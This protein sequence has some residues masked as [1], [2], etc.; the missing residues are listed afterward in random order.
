MGFKRRNFTDAL[1]AEVR[2][3]L[4]VGPGASK[5]ELLSR[6]RAR[7]GVRVSISRLT[8][9]LRRLLSRGKIEMVGSRASARFRALGPRSTES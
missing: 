2:G 7:P 1:E 5:A 4:A 9:A 8:L 6:L 3:L